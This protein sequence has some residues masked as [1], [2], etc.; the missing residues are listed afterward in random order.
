MVIYV[1]LWMSRDET[2]YAHISAKHKLSTFYNKAINFQIRMRNALVSR[3]RKM[4]QAVIIR[5]VTMTFFAFA[6][7]IL[8]FRL[9]S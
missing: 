9:D 1:A 3:D 5:D 8:N 2:Q 7:S 6:N 4:T